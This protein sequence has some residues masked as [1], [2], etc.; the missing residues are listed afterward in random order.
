MFANT[1]PKDSESYHTIV[2]AH[3]YLD[4]NGQKDIEIFNI[5]DSDD[6]HTDVFEDIDGTLLET[7][8][9]DFS[10]SESY[11]FMAHVR[12]WFH[13]YEDYFDGTQCEV[14][15]EVKELKDMN[16]FKVINLK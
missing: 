13:T 1:K 4:E 7:I 2:S 8:E 11:F 10:E 12:S 15:S 3:I 5:V 14:E 6:E 9:V 16:D